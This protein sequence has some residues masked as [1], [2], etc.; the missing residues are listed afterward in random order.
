[1]NMA[2]SKGRAD[3]YPLIALPA[4]DGGKSPRP[5]QNPTAGGSPKT[6]NHQ[7]QR[8][9]RRFGELAAALENQTMEVTSGRPARPEL[10]LAIDLATSLEEFRSLVA[11]TPGFEFLGD[12]DDTYPGDSSADSDAGTPHLDPPTGS[13]P[14]LYVAAADER[15]LSQIL[16]LWRAYQD[17]EQRSFRSVF[18]GWRTLFGLV[19]DIRE[20]GPSDRVA[21]ADFT[22]WRE[23]PLG[24]TDIYRAEVELW[25]REPNRPGN[26]AQEDALMRT[27]ADLGV[28][29]VDHIAESSINY[30]AFLV[31][32]SAQVAQE[33]LNLTS[34]LLF[35]RAVAH[36]RPQSVEAI[37][38]EAPGLTV[39]T[40]ALADREDQALGQPHVLL[41]DGVPDRGHPA[42]MDR[43]VLVDPLGLEAEVPLKAR[44]HG[45]GMASAILHGD[46]LDKNNRALTSS[47]MIAPLFTASRM[48]GGR[49]AE[50]LP[51]GRLPVSATK[52]LL[53][54]ALGS[55]MG[56]AIKVVVIAAGHTGNP[57]RGRMS[58]WA[59]LIDEYAVRLGLCFIVSA[60]NHAE[61]QIDLR[62]SAGADAS[63][64]ER[65]VQAMVRDAD[66]HRILSPAEAMNALTVGAEHVDR[67]PDALRSAGVDVVA[68]GQ[69]L[70]S[71]MSRGGGGLGGSL[72][73]DILAPGGR[74]KYRQRLADDESESTVLDRVQLNS[75]NGIEV[76]QPRVG[77]IDNGYRFMAGTSVAAGLAAHEAGL[78]AEMLDGPEPSAADAITRRRVATAL[79][80]L[81]INTAAWGSVVTRDGTDAS[82]W[83]APK[84]ATQKLMGYG[85]LRPDRVGQG[86]A[87]RVTIVTTG[88]INS[89]R[90][91]VVEVPLPVSLNGRRDRRRASVTLAWMT[92]I[93]P[94]SSGYKR[95]RL[96]FELANGKDVK[97]K[98][99][100]VLRESARKGTV[101]HE[102]FD[103]T[104][105][106]AVTE[107]LSLL[108]QINSAHDKP[109]K[110]K[111]STY[112]LV[113][114]FEVEESAEIPVYAEVA[115]AL[116]SRATVP[117]LG[118]TPNQ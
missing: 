16:V 73:P 86:A 27:F 57:F 13:N 107:G 6:P 38:S 42:L 29:V 99:S 9:S 95:E 84:R 113:V 21:D 50:T 65:V 61:N 63:L 7:G 43:I 53:D 108:I 117:R 109:D 49:W 20:W 59:R 41:I 15:A 23:R 2:V 46:L 97:L 19:V 22:P 58:P 68:E 116:R 1:M 14:T 67:V 8:L 51:T 105:A 44:V 3:A 82:D 64:E 33:I 114:T 103:G 102:H 87:E 112:A 74:P 12:F 34:P 56:S 35:S 36:I 26:S 75:K 106:V 5:R 47:I 45:T 52:T 62:V 31:D 83:R 91:Q 118:I 110:T 72:K 98:R 88:V 69:G 79:R 18:G 30:S 85:S 4:A 76:A 55:E 89:G 32:L 40:S 25:F 71:P 60:G 90:Q 80:A 48:P 17:D 39:A 66:R 24:S 37:D 92:T 96:H 93:N 81:L 100:T 94:Y 10:I 77:P 70:P 104:A 111:Q 115:Q 28:R 11:E 101:Q 54:A 78:L